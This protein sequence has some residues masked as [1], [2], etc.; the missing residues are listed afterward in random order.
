MNIDDRPTNQRPTTDLRAYS[1]I[2]GKFQ[3]AITLQ[4]VSRSPS[5]LVPGWGFRGRRIERRHFWLQQ[6]QDG[7]HLG[8]LQTAISQ[9][10]IIRFTACVY[11]DHILPWVSNL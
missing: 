1:H 10:R 2:L 5:C 6:I 9:Q 8:K 4:R 3:M 11:A 7:G